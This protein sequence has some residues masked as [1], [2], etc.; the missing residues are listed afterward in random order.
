MTNSKVFTLIFI[1]IFCF[2]LDAQDNSDFRI[3]LVD[4]TYEI[5]AKLLAIT[6]NKDSLEVLLANNSISCQ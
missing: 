2:N 6:L 4:Y 5:E 1:F 3:T